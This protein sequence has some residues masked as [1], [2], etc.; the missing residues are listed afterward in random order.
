M[1]SSYNL[2]LQ[3][4]LKSEGG[5]VNNPHD[6]GGATN[7]GIT[8]RTYNGWR[9]KTGKDFPNPVQHISL[10][11]V[12][13]IYRN[14]YW[15]TVQGDAL[16]AG[17]DYAV[18]DFGVNSGPSRALNTLAE[19]SGSTTQRIDQLCDIRLAFLK[20]LSSWQYFGNGWTT[21]VANVR[22]MAK[23]MATSPT[24]ALTAPTVETA[25]MTPREPQTMPQPHSTAPIG[26]LQAII[27]I[28]KMLFA[29][30]PKP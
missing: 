9:A 26:L 20:R 7:Y 24:I 3:A 2:A 19:T 28:I 5:Y 30:K 25:T 8:Q 10:D 17:L 13:A 21:R 23:N 1:Q 29:R 12:A 6:S 22:S 16:P 14:Q 4:V 18:F 11:E 15:D 27:E